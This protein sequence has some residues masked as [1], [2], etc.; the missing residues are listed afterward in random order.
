MKTKNLL[1]FMLMAVL[2]CLWGN[3]NA[4]DSKFCSRDIYHLGMEVESGTKVSLT[5]TNVDA[6]TVLVSIEKTGTLTPTSLSVET[7]VGN[8]SGVA[9]G[10][11]FEALITSATPPATF[12]I[13]AL[14]WN[15]NIIRPENYPDLTDISWGATCSGVIPSVNLKLS[16]LSLNPTVT[17]F[18]FSPT[19]QT[20]NVA[21][22]AG[23]TVTPEISPIVADGVVATIL[24]TTGSNVAISETMPVTAV[25]TV[26]EVGNITN[27]MLY[28]I[29]FTVKKAIDPLVSPLC[30]KTITYLNN[31]D[32][33]SAAA[34]SVAN[35]DANTVSVSLEQIAGGKEIAG[36]RIFSEQLGLITGAGDG[37]KYTAQWVV[38]GTA[39][40][41]FTIDWIEWNLVD[42]G[43]TCVARIANYEEFKDVS[44]VGKC[45]SGPTTLI[46]KSEIT[47]PYIFNTPGAINIAN[48]SSGDQIS[49]YDIS[50]KLV[51]S[52]V[53]EGAVE[54]ISLGKGLYVVKVTTENGTIVLKTVN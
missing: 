25:V 12:S 53:A 14:L 37:S 39:P 36:F 29:N 35:V 13:G 41:F 44:F 27:T 22:P 40:E 42:L 47:S 20:Y 54:T 52:A 28:T 43:V 19:T 18:T 7:S 5:I 50:G 11:K 15:G 24:S 46:S 31:G 17:G 49:V 45:S 10:N 21:L 33:G 30:E 1:S 26:A 16:S 3:A 32:M 2:C 23:T 38:S 51:K 9:N 8:F 6:N 34:L 4:Q 48:V